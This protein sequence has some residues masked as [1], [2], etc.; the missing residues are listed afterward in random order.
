MA[1]YALQHGDDSTARAAL[2]WVQS[3]MFT[4]GV[5]A[6]QYDMSDQP[7]SVAPLT[8][9]QAEYMSVLLDMITEQEAA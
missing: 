1:Q 9:S 4:S 6:E 2:D 3:V 7:L 8:W 5:L